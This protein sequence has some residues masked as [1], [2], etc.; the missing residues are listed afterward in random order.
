MTVPSLPPRTQVPSPPVDA[1]VDGAPKRPDSVIVLIQLA[2]AAIV[3]ESVAFVGN[4]SIMREQAV[5]LVRRD[6]RAAQTSEQYVTWATVGGMAIAIVLG[7]AVAVGALSAM[8]RGIGWARLLVAWLA[9]MAMV[10]MLFDVFGPM[11]GADIENA[12]PLWSMIPRIL[13]GVAAIGV[14]VTA[15]HADTR[16]YID[17]VAAHRTRRRPDSAPRK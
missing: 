13:G 4:Y 17:A 10:M 6:G 16:R 2:I 5:E 8:L 9:A 14:L 12:P 1:A 3:L 15:M 7:V 11:L